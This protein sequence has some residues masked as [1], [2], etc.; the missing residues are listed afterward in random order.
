MSFEKENSNVSEMYRVQ[1]YLSKY[2]SYVN[3][4]SNN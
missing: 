3:V 4:F 2:A 1:H